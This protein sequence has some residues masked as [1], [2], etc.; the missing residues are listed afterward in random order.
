MYHRINVVRPTTPAHSRGLIVHPTLFARHMAWLKRR[1]YETVTQRQLF[2]ALVLGRPLP[3]R[4]IMITFD[5]GYRDVFFRASPGLVRH[6]FSATAYVVSGRVSGP[7]PSF[8]TWGMLKALE[9]RGIEIGSHT[10]RHADL[11]ALSPRAALA[12]L[13]TSR[14]T[15]ERGLGHPVQW[16]AYPFGRFDARVERLA[17]QAGYVLATTTQPGARH[18][19]RRPL[20]LKRVRVLDTTG[21]SELAAL[22]GVHP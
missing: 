9:A 18:D 15:L 2:D 5:D 19:A 6:G 4:P 17:R 10:V 13:V 7:D 21:V 22:L 20:A 3:R 16:L 1:G 12:D 11:T 14:R 8:L